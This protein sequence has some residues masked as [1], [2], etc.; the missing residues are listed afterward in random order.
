MHSS[1]I[2]IVLLEL[3]VV[4][5]GNALANQ[6][7]QWATLIWLSVAA[8]AVTIFPAVLFR[9]TLASWFRAKGEVLASFGVLSVVVAVLGWGLY[10]GVSWLRNR[11]PPEVW[12]WAHP[13][14]SLEEQ[15]TNQ[16]ECRMGA[17]EATSDADPY[18]QPGLYR[19]YMEACLTSRGFKYEQAP[20]SD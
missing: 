1:Y 11:P 15:T 9:S 18:S 19:E 8:A 12:E 2:I 14:M 13:T 17:V 6:Y 4:A 20:A 3:F 16:A 5:L 10:S 7:P